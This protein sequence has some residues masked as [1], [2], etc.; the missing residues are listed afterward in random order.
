MNSFETLLKVF[1]QC[2]LI[3]HLSVF[4]SSHLSLTTWEQGEKN[5]TNWPS[6]MLLSEHVSIQDHLLHLVGVFIDCLVKIAA[7]GF[8]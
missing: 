5:P 1:L 4:V 7:E 2:V 8:L 3:C 6:N